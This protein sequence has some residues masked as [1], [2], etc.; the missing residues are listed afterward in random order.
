MS[1]L[2]DW[3]GAYEQPV[4]PGVY[5]IDGYGIGWGRQMW[6]H[7]NQAGWGWP[8]TSPEYARHPAIRVRSKTRGPWRGLTERAK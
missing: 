4:R 5:E 7:W 3:F 2:T 6:A 1:T 8:A